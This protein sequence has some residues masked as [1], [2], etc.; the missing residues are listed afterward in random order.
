MRAKEA[1]L[2]YSADGLHAELRKLKSWSVLEA[3]MPPF[4]A[5]GLVSSGILI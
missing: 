5:T 3:I 1:E 4:I 2:R